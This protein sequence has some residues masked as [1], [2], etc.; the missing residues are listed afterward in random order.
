VT[1]PQQ[2]IARWARGEEADADALVALALVCEAQ[3]GALDGPLSELSGIRSRALI[4]RLRELAGEAL[5]AH[6]ALSELADRIEELLGPLI[7]PADQEIA[8]LAFLVAEGAQSE[9]QL[10]GATDGVDEQRIGEWALDAAD[11]GLIE[12]VEPSSAMR[13]WHVTERGLAVLER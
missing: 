2:T 9:R 3:T 4:R 6:E 5:P 1:D 13:R 11:R 8:L 10:A 12:Q 7:L